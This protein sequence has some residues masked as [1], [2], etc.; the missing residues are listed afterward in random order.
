MKIYRILLFISAI[1]YMLPFITPYHCWWLIFLFPPLLFIA[2]NKKKL[3]WFDFC[4]W[5][6]TVSTIQI[7]PLC[8]AMFYMTNGSVWSRLPLSIALILYVALYPTSW[9]LLTNT[10]LKKFQSLTQKIFAWT[11]S[12]WLYLLFVNYAL[13]WIFGQCEGYI[14]ANP[15]LPL[16]TYP[17]LLGH[18]HWLSLPFA[19]LFY[20]ITTSALTLCI[21]QKTKST[22][23]CFI[24]ITLAWLI[25]SI[26]YKSTAAP[27]WLCAVGHLPIMLP[28]TIPLEKGAA[29]IAFELKQ[30]KKK[31][32]ELQL[33]ILPESAWNGLPCNAITTIHA[34]QDS[35][36]PPDVIIGSFAQ[37]NNR[38]FNSLYWFNS[39]QLKQR[40]DKQHAVPFIE[41]IPPGFTTL[42]NR[43]FFTKSSPIYPD[44]HPRQNI[45]I[46]NKLTFVPYICS[47]LFCNNH[48]TEQSQHPIL[49]SCSDWWFRLAY[50]RQLM[51]LAARFRAI[52]CSKPLLYI[53]FHYAQFFDQ[54]GTAYPISTTH[55]DRF[56]N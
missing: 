42:C 43:F 8:D 29:L 21:L 36:L 25:P 1:C 20:C 15:L 14:F 13:F 10:I 26:F 55:T 47:D 18:L 40:V 24:L 7:F 53:S 46:K 41:R 2:L 37:E 19:F 28:D 4:A 52:Q 5:G 50:F 22:I 35:R 27:S 31:Y 6:I 39:G 48:Q 23:I 54:Y 33:I 32:P 16:A 44:N 30:L 51:I 56:L 12:M 49:A 11:I 9:L 3:H 17:F 34:L 45:A 38:N